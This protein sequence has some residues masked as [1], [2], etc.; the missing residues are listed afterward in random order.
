MSK[1]LL[2][3]VITTD[4]YIDS[5]RD[6]MNGIVS[7]AF[8]AACNVIVLS[9]LK[10]YYD[11]LPENKTDE[12]VFNLILS[13]RFDGFIY[14]RN[15]FYN[16][17]I[18]EYI[19]DLCM[20][21]QKPVM[22]LDHK[23]HKKF[24]TISADDVEAFEKIIDH[25][26][27]VHN[28]KKI[29][30]LTGPKGTYIAENRLNGYI[31]SMKKHKLKYDKSYYF[32]GDF[33]KNSSVELVEK[34]CSGEIEKPDAVVCANDTM[35][36]SLT[37]RLIG[38]GIKVPEDIAVTGFDDSVNGYTMNPS[39]TSYRRPNFLLGAEAVRRIYR[40]ITGELC[41]KV[42]DD[43]S[44]LRL[45]QTCGCSGIPQIPHRIQRRM[46]VDEDFSADLSS[47]DM[48][49]QLINAENLSSVLDII[50][51]YTYLL[52][53][54]NHLLIC[55]TQ[56]YID[57]VSDGREIDGGFD[58]QTPM[59]IVYN[60]SAIKR[61]P[62]NNSV[63]YSNEFIDK[64]KNNKK[65]PSAYYISP[66]N[67]QDVF[68]G[69][70][71]VSFGKK[72]ETYSRLYH[73]WIKYINTALENMMHT[74]SMR[75]KIKRLNVR[76]ARDKS[77]MLLNTNG[78]EDA[79]Y[80]LKESCGGEQTITYIHIELPEL[81]KTYYRCGES[82]TLR[83]IRNFADI[84]RDS[85]NQ[86]EICGAVS[87][88]CFGAVLLGG[89]RS[90]EVFSFIKQRLESCVVNYDKSYGTA[91]TMGEFGGALS[92]FSSLGELR[93]K[94][95]LN[96]KYSYSHED[97]GINPQFERVC[98]LRSELMKH[99]EREW[100]VSEIAEKMFL[101]KSYLQKIYKQYFDRSIIDEMT[102]FRID[103]AKKLL[104]ETDMTVTDI[105]VECGYS[106]YNYFVRRFKILEGMSPSEYRCKYKY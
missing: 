16:D 19:D 31:N 102:H 15:S 13:D 69:Y 80:E 90:Q 75:L 52:Y 30:L 100:N 34:I 25:L 17:E 47:R 98:R 106:T 49:S 83:I 92:E 61:L 58:M 60:K 41:A 42:I 78:F 46:K 39:L 101:S 91:F 55:L 66:L 6:L 99:P 59:K 48:F 89:E 62:V 2:I 4:C 71:A 9:P 21:S 50:D 94:A 28:Y 97:M 29:Y 44:G 74:A 79:F 23:S 14:N 54:M 10:N 77:T 88:D 38:K 43:E 8:K 45:G 86:N 12:V 95:A 72:P 53:K 76:C 22:L 105:S 37:E 81:R 73:Q 63:V 18:R 33:W 36:L 32:Y 27:D 26:I 3:G 35:A 64:L 1:R 96:R 85:L 7:Q 24:D 57:G 67:F 103:K 40:I 20:R 56:S 84:F 87:S 68:C 70:C 11:R 93:H 51:S 104:V 5:Q 65:C 82:K